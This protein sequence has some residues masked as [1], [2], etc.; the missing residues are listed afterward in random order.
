MRIRSGIVHAA[1]LAGLLA[2]GAGTRA[3]GE[4]AR[5]E[6]RPHRVAALPAVPFL[7]VVALGYREA[8]ADVAWLQAVQYYGEHRQGGNDL[9]EFRHYVAAVNT[10]DP[11]YEHAYVFGAFVLATE[12][13]DRQ[14]ALDLLRRGVRANPSSGRLL[15]EMGFLHYVLGDEL[16]AALPYLRLA[17]RRPNGRERAQ[18]FMA[19]IERRLGRLETAWLLWQDILTT[20]RDPSMRAVAAQAMRSL[21][22]EMRQPR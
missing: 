17:A 12:S 2:A 21:E 3:L 16:E 14:G 15:F 18:R 9:S 19:F 4:R 10:L 8:A 7:E 13:G 22:R 1:V 6:G 20:S 5:G 11:R